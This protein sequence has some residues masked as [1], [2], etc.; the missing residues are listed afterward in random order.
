MAR[1]RNSF[2]F[3]LITLFS[4]CIS[5]SFATAVRPAVPEKPAISDIDL[6][7][8][9]LCG[10]TVALL[11]EPPM[12]GY[13]RTLQ[14]KVELVRRLIDECHYNAFFIES[15]IYDFI[16]IQKKLRSGQ[17]LTQTMIAAAIGGLWANREV[18]PLIPFLLKE[19]ERGN[20]VLGG[21]DDQLGRATYAQEGMPLDLV[22]RLQGDAKTQCLSILQKHMLWH[23]S[24]DSPYSPKDKALILGCL[25]K[26][27][28][29][30]SKTQFSDVPF[31]E[32]DIAMIESLKRNF[33]RDF[34]ADVQKNVDPS[35]EDF[36]A[37]DQSMYLNFQWLM[38]R[39]PSHSK[40]IVWAATT[41]VAK[42]LSGVPGQESKVSLGSYIR[43]AFND[44]SFVVGFSAYSGSYGMAR[45]PVRQ[46][47]VAPDLSLEGQA[48]AANN[49]DTR[50]FNLNELRKFGD[51]PARPLG[52]D[53]KT[54][55]WDEVLDGLVVFRE[56]QPPD[57]SKQ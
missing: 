32:Y 30:L 22:E 50:Y 7:V 42:D 46:L 53:F 14:F 1:V 10:K 11:G 16:N 17:Q 2:A 27:E 37:R 49:S 20:V 41:H 52:A 12:H 29:N 45:Q 28:T 6:V 4:V 35:I 13:G 39:L 38:S 34:R 47:S 24:N 19:A 44:N 48:F 36:V 56:E 25:D 31:R 40:V 26:I 57:F 21:L 3:G 5:G 8:H 15:G 43:R 33:A 54:A 23:Y 55:R 18:E 51:I 9:E